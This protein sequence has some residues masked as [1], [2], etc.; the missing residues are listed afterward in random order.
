M[1]LVDANV[2]LRY[3]MDDDEQLAEKAAAILE[4]AQV[5]VPFEILAEVVYVM[6]GVYKVS[7][8][9]I[10]EALARLVAYPNITT[11]NTPVLDEA[12]R[13]YSKMGLDFVDTLLCAYSRV[14]GAQIDTF[15][16]KLNKICSEKP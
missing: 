3:L 5:H 9:E 1:R 13:L 4:S 15:D 12:L 14:E 8:Q 2:I 6:Q 7:R 10:A 16:K 11:N